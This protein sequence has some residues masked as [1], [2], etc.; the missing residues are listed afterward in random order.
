M[1]RN[2]YT[3]QAPVLTVKATIFM[4]S[5]LLVL[6]EVVVHLAAAAAAAAVAVSSCGRGCDGKIM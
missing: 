3:P 6:M 4:T 5:Q 1:V 2:T